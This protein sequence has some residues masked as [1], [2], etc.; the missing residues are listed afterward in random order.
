M[1]SFSP[2]HLL[3]VGIVFLLLFGGRGKI[4]QIMGDAA[5]GIRAFQSGLKEG[6]DEQRNNAN[7][8]QT[9]GTLPRTE[10]E[11]EALRQAE[12]RADTRP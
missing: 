10:A 8:G 4:S 6:E 3:F 1:G 7:S 11:Q 12:T 2:W 5:K 9:P